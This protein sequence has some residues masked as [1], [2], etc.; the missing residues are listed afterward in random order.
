MQLTQEVSFPRGSKS[1]TKTDKPRIR[2][3]KPTNVRLL[4]HG[5]IN[6]KVMRFSSSSDLIANMSLR[7][8][9]RKENVQKLVKIIW[10][11]TN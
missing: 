1:S 3:Q 6:Y 5:N 11:K 2:I 9:N 10:K 8:R 7:K 4:W